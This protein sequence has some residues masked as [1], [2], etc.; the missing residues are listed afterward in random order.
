MEMPPDNAGV[1][2]PEGVVLE[3]PPSKPWELRQVI[4]RGL[5]EE[6]LTLTE[7]AVADLEEL[8]MLP[9]CNRAEKMAIAVHMGAMMMVTAREG[10]D[11]W[12]ALGRVRRW[13][14]HVY[15]AV[16]E[17][18]KVVSPQAEETEAEESDPK[19]STGGGL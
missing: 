10:P 15:A 12:A 5:F 6:P 8:A 7:L 11:W 18:M 3:Q 14:E 1:N 17:A 19:S 16:L 2:L 13:P 4:I 9:N